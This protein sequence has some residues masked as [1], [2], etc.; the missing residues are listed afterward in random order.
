MRGIWMT[1]GCG[2]SWLLANSVAAQVEV[3]TPDGSVVVRPPGR[4]VITT[5]APTRARGK[6]VRTVPGNGVV[7]RQPD[8]SDVVVYYG[9]GAAYWLGNRP[10]VLSEL[11]VGTEV[12][13]PYRIDGERYIYVPSTVSMGPI[14]T[15]QGRIAMD[16]K[17][18][19]LLLYSDDGRQVPLT[20]DDRDR[21]TVQVE[22]RDGRNVVRGITSVPVAT[23]QS[24][25]AVRGKVIR[26][27]EGFFVLRT[28]AGEEVTIY[29]DPNTRYSVSGADRVLGDIREGAEVTA[30]YVVEGAR[31]IGRTIVNGIHQIL[32]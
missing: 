21:A 31:M 29:T 18:G 28:P 14:T 24:S 25:K 4:V 16:A 12:E 5:A 27:G 30:D 7:V 8:G 13:L 9:P 26:V 32:P 15:L 19:R 6:I 23:F 17:S 10:V 11:P 3:Q 20:F 2:V 22:T 1:L